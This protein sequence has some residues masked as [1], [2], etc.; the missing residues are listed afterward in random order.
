MI[1]VSADVEL[2]AGN[3]RERAAAARCAAAF[4]RFDRAT[5]LVG[6]DGTDVLMS[7]RK[8]VLRASL[9]TVH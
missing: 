9:V 8:S 7:C 6:P 3:T 5:L 4:N 2:T 1:A